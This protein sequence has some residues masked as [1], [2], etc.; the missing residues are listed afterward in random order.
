[1]RR[2]SSTVSE[3]APLLLY[4]KYIIQPSTLLIIEEP[5]AHLHPGNQLVFA[6]Y[7]VKMIRKGLNVLITTHSVFLLEQ[8]SKYMQASEVSPEV[9]ST[10]LGFDTEDYLLAKE[11]SPCAFVNE[12]GGGHRIEPIGMDEEDGISQEEFVR[13]NEL[14]YE[15]SIKIQENLSDDHEY[16]QNN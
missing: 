11:V 10:T 3:M 7:I 14:L 15:Q 1:M 12:G 13:I 9:R 4:L 2:A 6:K 16:K 5:E 8:L